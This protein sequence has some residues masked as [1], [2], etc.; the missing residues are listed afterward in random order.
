MQIIIIRITEIKEDFLALLAKGKDL[1]AKYGR[2]LSK[3]ED[4]IKMR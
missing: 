1:E 3:K 4:W 2:I